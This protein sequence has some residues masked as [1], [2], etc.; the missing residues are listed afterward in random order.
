[1]EVISKKKNIKVRLNL[2]KRFI[3]ISFVILFCIG[4]A[5]SGAAGGTKSAPEYLI[6]AGY[7]YKY[8]LFFEWPASFFPTGSRNDNLVI[9]IIGDNP[10]GHYFDPIQGKQLKNLNKKIEIIHFGGFQKE[11]NP[12]ACHI[13]FISKS[14]SKHLQNILEKTRGKPVLT[15]ADQEGFLEKGGMINLLSV[16]DLIRWE[17]NLEAIEEAGLTVS[18]TIVQSAV[19]VARE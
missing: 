17:I 12:D 15:V 2:N 3:C 5:W 14:E 19:R 16:N 9:G 8:F 6:K 11:F 4:I 13:L 1:M 7:L 18:A 10:F